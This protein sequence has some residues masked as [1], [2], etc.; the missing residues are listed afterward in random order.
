MVQKQDSRYFLA[1]GQWVQ[2][3]VPRME[4]SR[5]SMHG[6]PLE[7]WHLGNRFETGHGKPDIESQRLLHPPA[8]KVRA[9]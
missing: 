4:T 6:K 1:E 2:E 8:K 9:A 7:W 3:W 5:N